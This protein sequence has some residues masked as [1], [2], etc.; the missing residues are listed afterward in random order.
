MVGTSAP[1]EFSTAVVG[2]SVVEDSS[3]AAAI[4]TEGQMANF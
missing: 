4:Q 3:T 2:P 1:V